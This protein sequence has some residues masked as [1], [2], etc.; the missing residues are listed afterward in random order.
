MSQ[1]TV[2]IPTPLRTFT[3]GAD[4]VRLHGST[5]G[6]L[7][8]AL[9]AAHAGLLPRVLDERGELRAFVNVFVGERNIRN[10]Q[11]LAT[12]VPEGAVLSIVPAVAGGG[13]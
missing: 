13:R 9:G 1:A 2:R 8:H 12:L 3:A 11:G 10:L 4:E 7:L 6:E 5:V